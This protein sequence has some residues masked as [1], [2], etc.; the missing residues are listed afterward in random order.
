MKFIWYPFI[1][2]QE[3]F[4]YGAKDLINDVITL[5]IELKSNYILATYPFN[6][7]NNEVQTIPTPQQAAV[8]K[9]TVGSEEKS[10]HS[11]YEVEPTP[12]GSTLGVFK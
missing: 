11:Q 6:Q 4:L 10:D 9:D 2:P 12:A 7:I 3:H 8:S 5:R 1:S